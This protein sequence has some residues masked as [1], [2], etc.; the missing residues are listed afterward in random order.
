MALV[1]DQENL[2]FAFHKLTLVSIRGA[3]LSSCIPRKGSTPLPSVSMVNF[4]EERQLL[5]T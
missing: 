1:V 3:L 4:T 5:K 2:F